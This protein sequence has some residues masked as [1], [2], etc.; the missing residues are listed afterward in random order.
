VEVEG[1]SRQETANCVAQ[2]ARLSQAPGG[3][4]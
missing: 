1:N 4:Q 2:T 3:A